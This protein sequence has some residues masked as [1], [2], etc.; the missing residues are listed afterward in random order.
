LA[1][2]TILRL[3]ANFILSPTL[4]DTWL[5]TCLLTTQSTSFV[6]IYLTGLIIYCKT[7]PFTISTIVT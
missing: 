7:T 2:M 1:D 3:S 6:E 5:R 4:M